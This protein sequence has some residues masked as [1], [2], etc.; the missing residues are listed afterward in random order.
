MDFQQKTTNSTATKLL[1]WQAA[2][3]VVGALLVVLCIIYGINFTVPF[4]VLI[5]AWFFKIGLQAR[6]DWR[7]LERSLQSNFDHDEFE[8]GQWVAVQGVARVLI[9]GADNLF[10]NVLAYYYR[11]S[12]LESGSPR[13]STSA[14]LSKRMAS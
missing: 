6:S 2:W 8:N 7:A 13:R 12:D 14:S 3:L 5:S 11:V 10:P 4:L 9:P 1:L